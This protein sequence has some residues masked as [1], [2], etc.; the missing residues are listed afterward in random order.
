MS[1]HSPFSFKKRR[2]AKRINRIGLSRG[3][4]KS[5]PLGNR[6]KSSAPLHEAQVLD[7]IHSPEPKDKSSKG[8]WD[9]STIGEVRQLHDKWFK[10]FNA[11]A[12]RALSRRKVAPAKIAILNALLHQSGATSTPTLIAEGACGT[13]WEILHQHL[14]QKVGQEPSTEMALVTFI[15]GDG[16]TSHKTTEIDLYASQRK[17]QKTLRAMA[18]NWF[19]VTELALFNSQGY[20]G[21]GQLV[22]RHEHEI[23][24]GSNILSRARAVAAKHEGLFLPNSTGAPTINI[25]RV[26]N[27]EV[28]LAR[29]C[30]YLFKPPYKCMNWNPGR[31]PYERQREGR[32]LHSIPEACPIPEHV[33]VRANYIWRRRRLPNPQ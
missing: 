7:A 17:V 19:G 26:A 11:K 8:L 3:S 33:D 10:I 22:Q 15:S 4:S 20:P 31:G 13:A 14:W 9:C 12:I 1:R 18:P 32:S 23:I 6:R 27:D 25:K 24:Y 16:A 21:G 2:F 29:V 28:N 5:A 30:A